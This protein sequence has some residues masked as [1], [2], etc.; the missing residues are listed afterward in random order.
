VGL[1]LVLEWYGAAS[2]VPWLFLLSAWI[3]ALIVAT[4]AYAAWNRSGLRLRLEARGSRPAAGSPVEALPDNLLR[5]APWPAPVFEGDGLELE[6][7]LT[8]SGAPR[9]PAWVR[10][11]VGGRPV[12][13]GA[14]LV[15]RAG[16][17][18]VEVLHGLRRGAIGATGWQLGTSD[19]LGFFSGVRSCPDVEV[20]V[21][22]PLFTS[23]VSSRQP[24]ELEASVAAPRAGSGNDLFGIREYR[25]GDSLRR[26]HWRSSARHGELVVREYEPPGMRT[27]ALFVDPSPR[28]VEVA[29]QVAR[30][31]ASEAWD[32]I[33]EG[34]RV[35]LWAPGLEATDP[36]QGRDLWAILE[37]LARYPAVQ[38]GDVP[39]AY[40][41]NGE[42]VV[43]TGSGDPRLIDAAELAKQRGA[44]VRVWVVGDAEIDLDA[45]ERRVGTEWPV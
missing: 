45:P 39:D 19:P 21:V 37:W 34:G 13:F 22:L 5:S 26:I 18:R 36:S 25:P 15:P 12:T 7:G 9:G 28:S 4:F 11:L 27:V 33:R 14:G 10:G 31:A 29:D 2:E 32:C 16:W 44:G 24:H 41:A 38:S 35:S 30:L 42:V 40:Q 1:W 20:A 6:A 3:L 43:I 23:L 8:T 17:R